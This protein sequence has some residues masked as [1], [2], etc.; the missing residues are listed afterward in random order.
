MTP[1]LQ[2]LDV[3]INRSFQ[4]FFGEKY[5]EWIANAIEDETMLTKQGNVK[6]RII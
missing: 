4:Q 1:I 5:D 3:S 6:V 2:P